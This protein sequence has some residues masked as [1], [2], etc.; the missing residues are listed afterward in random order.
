M[1]NEDSENILL[2]K[3]LT[4]SAKS[5]EPAS[6]VTHLRKSSIAS[7]AASFGT[8][9]EKESTSTNGENFRNVR[10][11]CSQQVSNPK[12]NQTHQKQ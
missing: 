12:V 1:N 9:T 6:S 3:Q 11:R 2:A 8:K 7:Y 4:K 5:V 10:R